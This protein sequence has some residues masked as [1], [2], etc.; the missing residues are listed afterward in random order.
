MIPCLAVL[1]S[2]IGKVM[3]ACGSCLYQLFCPDI[4][5]RKGLLNLVLLSSA[6]SHIHEGGGSSFQFKKTENW[7][8]FKSWILQSLRLLSSKANMMLQWVAIGDCCRGSW[9]FCL[10]WHFQ[11]WASEQ[12]LPLAVTFGLQQKQEEFVHNTRCANISQA[13]SV[14]VGQ[15]CQK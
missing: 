12:S 5:L 1:V 3:V 6:R 8:A 10:L 7:K 14:G 2:T 13:L 4:P 15:P 9:L 11:R